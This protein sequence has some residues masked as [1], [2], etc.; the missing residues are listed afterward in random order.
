MWTQVVRL[1]KTFQANGP[2]VSGRKTVSHPLVN[3]HSLYRVEYTIAVLNGANNFSTFIDATAIKCLVKYTDHWVFDFLFCHHL[4]RM[5]ER[6]THIQTC[7]QLPFALSTCSGVFHV[8]VSMEQRRGP[9]GSLYT[10]SSISCRWWAARRRSSVTAKTMH[11]RNNSRTTRDRPVARRD[12]FKL[13]CLDS[14]KLNELFLITFILVRTFSAF[15][16]NT[17]IVNPL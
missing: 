12:K 2:H 13:R 14:H 8:M 1:T 10:F 5:F 3:A 6:W 9:F 16:W 11:W 15:R 4:L 17:T 7:F